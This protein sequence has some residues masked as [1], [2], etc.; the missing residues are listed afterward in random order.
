LPQ[1]DMLHVLAIEKRVPFSVESQTPLTDFDVIAICINCEINQVNAVRLLTICGLPVKASERTDALPY[2]FVGGLN[3]PEP[4]AEMCDAVFLG[5]FEDNA[6]AVIDALFRTKGHSRTERNDALAQVPGM[7]IPSRYRFDPELGVVPVSSAYPATV[8][9][10]FARSFETDY[11]PKQWVLPYTQPVFDRFQVEVQRG[12]PN[13]CTF[14]QARCVYHPYRERSPQ[15]VMQAVDAYYRQTGH[16]DMSLLGLSVVDYSAIDTLLDELIPYCQKRKISLSVPSIR[17]TPKALD[18]MER[19]S[20]GGKR[21]SMTLAMEAADDDLRRSF[22]KVIKND[23]V[24]TMVLEGARRGYRTFKF[25]YL[26][27]FPGEDDGHIDRIADFVERCAQAVR[28]EKGFWPQM[29]VSVNCLMPKPFSVLERTS[30]LDETSYLARVNRLKERFFKKKNHM[31]NFLDY[32]QVVIESLLARGDRTM[33]AAVC[34]VASVISQDANLL[35]DRAIW[36]AAC[37]RTGVNVERITCSADSLPV[38][39]VTA[40]DAHLQRSE[41]ANG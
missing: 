21:P 1:D 30:L 40:R 39:I 31:V 22:G 35:F 25:Y 4:I 36:L 10:V 32:G 18:V 28:E 29:N 19:L 24:F 13:Q 3:N 26:T 5:E 11:A 8:S 38:H 33:F 7:Y 9:R 34:E 6:P 23:D 12:C 17:P 27:G 20:F 14:C 15:L 2:I 16:D 37:E 41:K